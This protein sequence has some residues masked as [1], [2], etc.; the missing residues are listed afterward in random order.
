MAQIDLQK[1]RTRCLDDDEFVGQMLKIF[2]EVAP[3]T[4][5]S[6]RDA[7]SSGDLPA[8]RRHAHTLKG[9]AA[10]LSAELLRIAAAEA[11]TQADHQD[12]AGLAASVG[13]IGMLLERTIAE[14]ASVAESL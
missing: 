12:T 8:A 10:N 9:S 1:L 4:F 5:E 13:R 3:R 6:L 14:A 2:S 11:E 7:V